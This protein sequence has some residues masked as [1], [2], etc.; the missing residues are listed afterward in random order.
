MPPASG[1]TTNIEPA[2]PKS[3]RPW[4]R[5]VRWVITAAV[6]AATFWFMGEQ[7]RAA[8]SDLKK[9]PFTFRFEW[10]IVSVLFFAVG[11]I[12][13]SGS[14][15]LIL[16]DRIRAIGL[17]I[18][19]SLGESIRSFLIS[20]V[21]K[22]VPGKAFVLVLRYGLLGSKGAT[23]GL[24]TLATIFET[25]CTM[26]TASIVG[27]TI[28]LLP[29]APALNAALLET[30]W[31]L[32]MAILFAVG[33]VGAISP[34]LFSLLPRIFSFVVPAAKRHADDWIKWKTFLLSLPIGCV[35]W[36]FLGLSFW[37]TVQAVSPT[38]LGWT[39]IPPLTAVFALSFVAGFLS[40]IPGQLGV[41]E[42]MLMVVL[43]HVLEGDELVTVSATL[44]SRLITLA[45]EFILAGGLLLTLRGPL[46]KLPARGT[47][48]DLS[49]LVTTDD[50]KIEHGT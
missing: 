31:L 38:P 37:A 25:F 42:A 2:P 27:L 13:L 32:P 50:G 41:R 17:P 21:G 49:P 36:L 34:P 16:Q 3:G 46:A 40:M 10:V 11:M 33:F 6:L 20:Q 47:A 26:A 22:Y 19:I 9:K 43:E 8:I 18:K 48:T 4:V 45:T 35:A 7:I 24:V 28:L 44:L 14:W 39:D 23:L 5:I 1:V 29:S 12:T 30:P 15:Y